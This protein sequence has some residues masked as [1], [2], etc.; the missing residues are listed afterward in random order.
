MIDLEMLD[1]IYCTEC[2]A[3]VTSKDVDE[4]TLSRQVATVSENRP[5]GHVAAATAGSKA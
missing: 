3:Q 2:S 5:C 4:G 1:G